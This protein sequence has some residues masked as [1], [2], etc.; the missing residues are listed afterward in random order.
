MDKENREIIQ[1]F[2]DELM[3]QKGKENERFIRDAIRIV[4]RELEDFPLYG[5]KQG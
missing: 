2:L 5:P 1:N 3:K 4:E